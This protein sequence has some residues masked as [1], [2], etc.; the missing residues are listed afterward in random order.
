MAEPIEILN[1]DDRP[2]ALKTLKRAIKGASGAD[3]KHL[4]SVL[5]SLNPDAA[6]SRA[7]KG[8]SSMAKSTKKA[9]G[10]KTGHHHKHTQRRGNP[11]LKEAAGKAKEKVRVITRRAASNFKSADVMGILTEGAGVGVGLVLTNIAAKQAEKFLP[12]SLPG[13]VKSILAAGVVGGGAVAFGGTR[14]FT[15]Y[16]AVGAIAEAIHSAA[17]NYLPSGLM[18]GTDAASLPSPAG[19]WDASTGQW[20][21]TDGQGMAGVIWD[22]SLPMPDFTER[23]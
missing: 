20:V 13:V 18:A 14:G 23:P 22:P 11:T 4:L 19:Y 7:F 5:R 15:R 17:R 9:A 2:H 6:R 12:A 1:G 16:I 3:R 8:A 21:P 10:Q